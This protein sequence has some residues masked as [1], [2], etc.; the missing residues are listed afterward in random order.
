MMLSV[1]QQRPVPFGHCTGKGRR[2]TGHC[3]DLPL[4]RFLSLLLQCTS[5]VVLDVHSRSI[6]LVGDLELF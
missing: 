2:C 3:N 4:V 6:T 1:G 5:N